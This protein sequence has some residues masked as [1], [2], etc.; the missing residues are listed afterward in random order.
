MR[1]SQATHLS[2]HKDLF[3]WMNTF[4]LQ[5]EA[6]PLFPSLTAVLPGSISSSSLL[7]KS[8]TCTESFWTTGPV[9]SHL[10]QPSSLQGLLWTHGIYE[11]HPWVLVYIPGACIC[12]PFHVPRAPPL[13][14]RLSP[15]TG[16][17]QP[18]S[19]GQMSPLWAPTREPR[20]HKGT[21]FRSFSNYGPWK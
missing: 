6:R 9:V 14:S 2:K 7:V 15:P 13:A 4:V 18:Q 11:I 1:Q 21:S 20:P 3:S 12:L 5:E 19:L 16:L 17:G 10:P 8:W